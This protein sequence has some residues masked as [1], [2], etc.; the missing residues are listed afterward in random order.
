MSTGRS[1]EGPERL[2]R[3]FELGE[4]QAVSALDSRLTQIETQTLALAEGLPGQFEAR[5]NDLL[6]RLT[7]AKAEGEQR[8]EDFRRKLLTAAVSEDE[9]RARLVMLDMEYASRLRLAEEGLGLL[10]ESVRTGLKV[11]REG[12]KQLIDEVRDSIRLQV[13]PSRGRIAQE[14]R[15]KAERVA[16]LEKAVA[17]VREAEAVRR[18]LEESVQALES[19]LREAAASGAQ[20]ETESQELKGEAAE[21]RSLLEAERAE[22]K[23]E[24]ESA[25]REKDELRLQSGRLKG[26][27][28]ETAAAW[29]HAKGE[30]DALKLRSEALSEEL[31]AA[32]AAKDEAEKA[33]AVVEEY[34]TAA[35]PALDKARHCLEAARRA[36]HHLRQERD[37]ARK[38][39][40]DAALARDQAAAAHAALEK[41]RAEHQVHVHELA[42]RLW[43]AESDRDRAQAALEHSKEDLQTLLQEHQALLVEN[44]GL[45]ESALQEAQSPQ[46]GPPPP[47]APA[48]VPQVEF[49]VAEPAHE[50]HS[51]PE[52]AQCGGTSVPPT[53]PDPE[54]AKLKEENAALLSDLDLMKARLKVAEASGSRLTEADLQWLDQRAQ[55]EDTLSQQARDINT[56]KLEWETRER[57]WVDT[58]SRQDAERVQEL[59]KLRAKIQQLKWALEKDKDS[60]K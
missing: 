45:K 25:T 37:E 18:S 23:Q 5:M 47:P 20:K 58:V 57:E 39:L 2:L 1:E 13:S 4:A 60:P 48:S 42:E 28:D 38:S 15:V 49:T 32:L 31:H 26:R 24:G 30:V 8:A 51:S 14:L 6:R 40:E 54:L 7:E 22:R 46:G 27:L 56:L 33:K 21:L 35:R 50:P 41:E 59:F 11:S 3:E 16:E 9:F 53:L 10:A 29:A 44:M 55:T 19:R 17:P 36:M 12:A 52:A 43:Q 34:K